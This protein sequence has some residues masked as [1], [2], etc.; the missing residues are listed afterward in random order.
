M[1]ADMLNLPFPLG[2]DL[3]M[4]MPV[5]LGYLVLGLLVLGLLGAAGFIAARLGYNPL[6]SLLLL[7]PVT[8]VLVFWWVALAKWPREKLND[9]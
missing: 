7:V 1:I 9:S 2:I 4:L 8:Q 5:W 6:L 3:L